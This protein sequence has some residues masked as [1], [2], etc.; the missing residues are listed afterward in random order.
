MF[1]IFAKNT[2][3]CCILGEFTIISQPSKVDIGYIFGMGVKTC[4]DVFGLGVRG[5]LTKIGLVRSEIAIRK[6]KK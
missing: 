4:V 3:L 6:K 2:K 1:Q 5:W